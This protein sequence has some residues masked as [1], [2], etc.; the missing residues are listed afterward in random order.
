MKHLL[1]ESTLE[2][3]SSLREK[4]PSGEVLIEKLIE[5]KKIIKEK[6]KDIRRH[7]TWENHITNYVS[8]VKYSKMV[9]P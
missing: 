6:E 8:L 7:V 4:L 3:I 1:V 5:Q 2:Q 9:Q